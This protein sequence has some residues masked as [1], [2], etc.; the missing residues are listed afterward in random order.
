MLKL[1]IT[2]HLTRDAVM[3]EVDIAG[4]KTPVCSFTVAANYGRKNEAG[5]RAVQYVNVTAWR[6]HAKKLYPYLKKGTNV[7]V[8]GP[9]RVSVYQST[10]DQSWRGTLEIS[11]I[12]DFEFLSAQQK[13]EEIPAPA[14]PTAADAPEDDGYPFA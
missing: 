4:V 6:E 8:G 10:Q 9:S 11:R 14:A 7:F 13:V 12:E 2:G 5:E 1:T 3:R